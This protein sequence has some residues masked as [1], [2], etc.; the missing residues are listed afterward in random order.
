[1]IKINLLILILSLL[2]SSHAEDQADW[3]DPFDLEPV[4]V[5]PFYAGYLPLS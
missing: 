1:M 5:H 2:L 4:L 3:V